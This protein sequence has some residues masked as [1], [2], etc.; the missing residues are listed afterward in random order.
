MPSKSA[1]VM[2]H[3]V[4][5]QRNEEQAIDV[6]EEIQQK[7]ST[8]VKTKGRFQVEIPTNGY[9]SRVD[10][11]WARKANPDAHAALMHREQQDIKMLQKKKKSRE[12][13]STLWKVQKGSTQNMLSNVRT[14]NQSSM[15]EEKLASGSINR[16]SIT[17]SLKSVAF[18]SN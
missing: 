4:T 1:C 6:L 15:M 17:K 2:G 9:L 7:V 5:L 3:A 8:K 13:S 10:N 12:L 14:S 18:M 16:R 11:E